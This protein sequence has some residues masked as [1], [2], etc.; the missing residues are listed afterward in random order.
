M[1]HPHVTRAA[2]PVDPASA[3][4]PADDAQLE[5]DRGVGWL[6]FVAIVIALAGVLNLIYGIAAISSSA[7]YA[8]GVDFIVGGLETY[9][10]LMLVTGA[11]QFVAAFGVLAFAEWGRWVGAVAAGG[12]AVVQLLVMP[13]A[14][15]LA[16]TIFAVDVL[17]A[18]G[19]IAYG[20]RWRAA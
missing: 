4:R 19:L 9:G 14:P 6:V 17:V 8:R 15:F 18:Y 13:A 20:G 1:S 7:F 11:G 2:G 16:L 5:A 10:W 12:N 3:G